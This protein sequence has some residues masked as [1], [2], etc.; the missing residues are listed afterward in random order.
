MDEMLHT[1][2]EK[3]RT[4]S[5]EELKSQKKMLADMHSNELKIL[6]DQFDQLKELNEKLEHKL[7]S[8]ENQYDDLMSDYRVI[9]SKL[10]NECHE[11]RSEIKVKSFELER[12]NL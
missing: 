2:L 4:K 11:L 9:R 10:E 6:R 3:I 8:R 5:D 7:R 12:L 1:E